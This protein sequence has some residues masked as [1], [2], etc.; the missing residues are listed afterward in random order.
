[1]V[2]DARVAYCAILESVPSAESCSLPSNDSTGLE[3]IMALPPPIPDLHISVKV[4][5]MT[6]VPE[7]EVA[8]QEVAVDTEAHVTSL[9]GWFSQFLQISCAIINCGDFDFGIVGVHSDESPGGDLH[10]LA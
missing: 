9:E 7:A 1:M 6:E 8:E 10:Q 3:S 4:P 2:D 5:H